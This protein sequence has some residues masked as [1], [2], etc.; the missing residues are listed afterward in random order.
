MRNVFSKFILTCSTMMTFGSAVYASTIYVDQ[1][2]DLSAPQSYTL[3]S[4]Q[5]WQDTPAFNGGFNVP[6]ANGDT[7]D[8]TIHFLA[9]QS[10]TVTNLSFVWAY[11][12]ADTSTDVNA[13]G[14]ITFLDATGSPLLTS[15]Q[16]T[17]EEGA[18]HLGQNFY[19]F[20]FTGA[21]G[22]PTTFT[23]YGVHYIGTVNNYIDPTITTRNYDEPAFIFGA[24]STS[25]YVPEPSSFALIGLGG[26]ALAVGAYRRRRT[27]TAA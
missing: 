18:A 1:T 3:P 6:I 4:F 20:N 9:R 27:Q 10:I 19:S 11:S 25:I 26:I 24:D 21:G 7:F 5:G 14:T 17:D 23:F 12:Y 13:T 8:F 2:L 16:V 22:L 15:D